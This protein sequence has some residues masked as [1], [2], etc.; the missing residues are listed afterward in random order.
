MYQLARR[1]PWVLT[2]PEPGIRIFDQSMPLL[3]TSGIGIT[4]GA[5]VLFANINV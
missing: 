3:T 5:D 2:Y 4:Y 1:S